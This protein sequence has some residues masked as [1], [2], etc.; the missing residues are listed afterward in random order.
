[1][2]TVPS[3]LR[4]AMPRTLKFDAIAA[5]GR[6]CRLPAETYKMNLT[7]HQNYRL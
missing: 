1:M 3:G 4:G 6:N 2:G 7:Y 5:I